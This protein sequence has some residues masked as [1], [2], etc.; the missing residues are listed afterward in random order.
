MEDIQKEA[1]ETA[2]QVLREK[3]RIK[4]E[5][6]KTILKEAENRRLSKDEIVA[7]MEE[8]KINKGGGQNGAH[9]NQRRSC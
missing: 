9:K 1:L 8:V 5:M 6:L 7:L 2:N 4:D 3:L